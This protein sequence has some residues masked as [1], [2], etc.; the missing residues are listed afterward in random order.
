MNFVTAGFSL[1]S[2]DSMACLFWRTFKQ[3]VEA[4]LCAISHDLLWHIFT[5]S[6]HR[7]WGRNSREGKEGRDKHLIMLPQYM[8]SP[9]DYKPRAIVVEDNTAPL[10]QL[11]RASDF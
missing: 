1:P 6:A 8:R 5:S 4:W 3:A 7:S 2:W 10:A 9:C 11:D